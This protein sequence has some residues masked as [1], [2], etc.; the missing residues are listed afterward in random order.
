MDE[1]PPQSSSVEQYLHALASIPPGAPYSVLP[2][3][4]VALEAQASAAQG[5]AGRA[6]LRA[7]VLRAAS[8]GSF[9]RASCRLDDE[10]LARIQASRQRIL[11]KCRGTMFPAGAR[12]VQP[13]A[14]IPRR[15]ATSGGPLQALRFAGLLAALRA[16]R[17]VFQVHV[18]PD[19]LDE[20]SEGG[21]R[22]TLGRI[23][24]VL[25][26]NPDTRAVF[27]SSWLYAPNL[28]EV[29]PRLAYIREVALQ[30]GCRF[31]RYGPD[32]SQDALEKSPT[33]RRLAEEGRYTP[34]VFAAVWPRDELIGH[35][36][37]W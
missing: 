25:A 27:G 19:E 34:T 3:R 35:A 14:G 8:R 13:G 29:S 37:C 12:L 28:P 32:P 22:R 26:L 31:F 4:A 10:T 30:S 36:S 7:E 1:A 16:H 23:A 5:E 11:A 15:I 17:P 21:W 9:F 33:R 24:R 2:D 6:R 18:H 20:F